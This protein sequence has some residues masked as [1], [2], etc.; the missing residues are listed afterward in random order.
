M[1][2]REER[3]LIERMGSGCLQFAGGVVALI[4]SLV[5]CALI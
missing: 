2:E 4:V 1:D 5:I 3:E